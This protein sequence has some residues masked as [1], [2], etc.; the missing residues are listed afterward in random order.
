MSTATLSNKDMALHYARDL[1]WAIHPVN[2]TKMPTTEHGRDDATHDEETIRR[3]FHNGA[4]IGVATGPESGILALDVDVK[5]D[6]DI[7]ARPILAELEKQH[8]ELPRTPIQ[9][10]GSGGLQYLFNYVEGVRNSQSRLGRGL[11]I[12]GAGGYIVVAP[13]HNTS[14]PY[15]WLVSPD[16]CPIADAPAW[17]IDLA[18]KPERPAPMLVSSFTSRDVAPYVDRAFK[19]EIANVATA[20][21]GQKHEVLRN[22]A[23]KLATLISHGL[24]E[25]DIESALF[26]AISGRVDDARNAAKTIQDGIAYGKMYP[27]AIPERP[28]ALT[29]AP[30]QPSYDDTGYI[31]PAAPS[32]P[33]VRPRLWLTEQEVDTSLVPPEML[34]KD[35]VVAEEVTVVFG[36]GDSG[37]TFIVVDIAMRIA[38]HYPVLYVAGEDG[39][40]IKI[41]KA[42]WQRHYNRPANGNFF[43]VNGPINLM[44]AGAVD[45]FITQAHPLGLKLIVFDTLSQCSAGADD[46]SNKEMSILTA[47]ANR[48]A[49]ELHTSVIIIH[50]TTKGG[51]NYRGASCIKDNTY[52][53]L[54]VEKDDDAITFECVRIKNTD[55]F[56]PRKYRLIADI[57]TGILKRDGTIATSCVIAPAIRTA[58]SDS[59]TNSEIKILETAGYVC[60]AQGHVGATEL[61]RATGLEGKKFWGPL[62]KL[63]D[64]GMLS[65][66]KQRTAPYFLT[67]R[68]KNFLNSAYKEDRSQ[69]DHDDQ[70]PALFEVNVQLDG[71]VTSFLGEVTTKLLPGSNQ[72]S[73]QEVTSYGEITYRA[74]DGFDTPQT[75]HQDDDDLWGVTTEVTSSN[76]TS[77]PS[78]PLLGG[79]K[80]V[81]EGSNEG[82]N[83]EVPAT[84]NYMQLDWAFVMRMYAMNDLPAIERHCSINRASYADVLAELQ[85][86]S[87]DEDE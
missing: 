48:I 1:G 71:K 7:D 16:E 82:S 34:V 38:Q 42:A 84:P 53:F 58:P 29:Y 83:T 76:V 51:E 63:K 54:R 4:Q 64:K 52:G 57:D 80:G 86:P 26:N 44:D 28:Q 85:S 69:Y 31:E 18:R 33:A 60:K 20:P 6:K 78:S 74:I 75:A 61:Q 22:A 5:P 9:R 11:D 19:D 30:R 72:G 35:V 45:E 43:L 68:A 36:L 14:G 66:G 27:R 23:V 3:Y 49:H 55:V 87:K 39:S 10:T 70:E 8:G 41:R 15:E 40:G 37:K 24:D 79:G 77:S 67:E 59:L 56:K 47:N 50:H 32:A 2:K 17:L 46:S 62:G 12:R 73:N 13:S 81:T 21:D 25:R 65:K